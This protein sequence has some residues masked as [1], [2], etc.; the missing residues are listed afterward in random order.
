MFLGTRPDSGMNEVFREPPDSRLAANVRLDCMSLDLVRPVR[1]PYH[2]AHPSP[3]RRGIPEQQR[4]DVLLPHT[5]FTNSAKA[6][7]TTSSPPAELEARSPP[8]KRRCCLMATVI[9]WAVISPA[10]QAAVG[11]FSHRL[12]KDTRYCLLPP[13]PH[14]S[15]PLL[16]GL[17]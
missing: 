17:G 4:G 12:E 15:S 9:H 1:W 10:G 2:G 11:L 5:R 14:A 16:L 6:K 13:T 8:A 7:C 3:G